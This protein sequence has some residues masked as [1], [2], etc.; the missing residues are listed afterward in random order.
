M[1]AQILWTIKEGLAGG[2]EELLPGECIDITLVYSVYISPLSI[3]SKWTS[4]S[5]ALNETGDPEPWHSAV[6][7]QDYGK[8]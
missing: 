7:W 2:L 4:P 1:Y 6:R 5:S 3:R 8:V